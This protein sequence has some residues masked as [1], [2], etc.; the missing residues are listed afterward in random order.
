MIAFCRHFVNWVK[1][2][3][4]GGGK[5]LAT[6]SVN[7]SQAYFPKKNIRSNLQ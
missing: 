7:Q 2:T 6:C 3:S 5:K 1:I 4:A